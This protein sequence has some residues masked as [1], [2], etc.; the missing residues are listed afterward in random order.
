MKAIVIGGAGFIGINT[1]YSFIGKGYEVVV[2]DNLSRKGS[3]YNLAQL[4]R[5]HDIPFYESD[6]RD[7]EAMRN[8]FERERDVD[9]V[10]LL[11]G[12]VAVT[13]SVTDPREDFDINALGTFNVLE[14]IRLSGQK[15]LLIYSSTNKVYG[16]ME[17]LAVAEHETRYDYRDLRTGVREDRQLDF[18]SPYGC[19]KGAG[20]QYVRDYHRIYGIPTVVFRQSCIYGTH[21]FGIE[22]QG[23]VAWFTIATLMERDITIYGDGKQIRDVLFVEDLVDLYDLAIHKRHEVAGKI[24]NIG[25][26]PGLTLSLNELIAILEKRFDRK[27][28]MSHSDWRPGDQKVYVSDIGKAARE[29]GWSP[30]TDVQSGI[31]RMADWIESNRDIL[32][33]Y[34]FGKPLP[35]TET[36]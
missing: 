9:A 16:K 30:R 21:Q 20:D 28:G 23:W 31:D 3:A 22:D 10:L 34:V 6:I 12:Q 29:L 15:P 26:G 5:E 27:I 32:N 25:G 4:R 33:H 36:A 17:E 2:V 35:S 11:A 19:S 1:V 24:Y 18:Y 8:L 7:A 14:G 13:T